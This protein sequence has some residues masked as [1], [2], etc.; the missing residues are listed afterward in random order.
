M[1]KIIFTMIALLMCGV[2]SAQ[3]LTVSSQSPNN[4]NKPYFG[5]R[6]EGDVMFPG[7]LKVE[8]VGVSIFNIGGGIAFGGIYNMPVSSNVYVEPGVKFFYNRY[9]VKDKFVEII[10]D[11][12]DTDDLSGV[13]IRK[14]GFRIPVML[15]YRLD[16]SGDSKVNIFTGPELEVG[17]SGKECAKSN[18]YDISESIYG[19]DGGMKRVD[20]SWT[21]GISKQSG[22]FCYGLSGSLGLLNMF[23]SS[24][25]KFHENRV[26]LSVGYNF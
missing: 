17:L 8:N 12:I 23:D 9:S 2:V 7:K 26:T 11:N 20:L 4:G 22:K 10:R 3:S 18:N 24:E 14:F 19:E 15:G 16:L 25:V 13:S 21:L 5:V 6:I 1:K